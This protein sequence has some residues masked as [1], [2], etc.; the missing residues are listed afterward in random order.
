MTQKCLAYTSTTKL[1]SQVPAAVILC[2]PTYLLA[3]RD[4]PD[5]LTLQTYEYSTIEATV[6]DCSLTKQKCGPSYYTY[7]VCF[8]AALI[9]EGQD[10]TASDITG[11]VDLGCLKQ[12]IDDKVGWEINLVDNEDGT[13]TL[14]SQHGC[15]YTFYGSLAPMALEPFVDINVKSAA[16]QIGTGAVRLSGFY[17]YNRNEDEVFLKFYDQADAPD[18][19]TDAPIHVYPIP[20]DQKGATVDW[21]LQRPFVNGCWIRACLGISNTDVTDVNDNDVIANTDFVG[22]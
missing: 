5:D 19:A 1:T 4:C 15:E 7:T 3:R 10:I 14:T 6:V 17:I 12:Y 2:V 21:A 11:L 13:L 16:V 8:D 18:P 20:P 22:V 9:A